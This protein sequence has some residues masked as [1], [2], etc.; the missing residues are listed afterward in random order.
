MS[1]DQVGKAIKEAFLFFKQIFSDTARLLSIVEESMNRHKLT[2]LWGSAAMWD[3]SYAFYGDHGW[4]VHYL[5]RLFVKLPQ[6]DKKTSF[7]EEKKGAFVNVYFEPEK[8]SEPIIVYGIITSI[9]D[10]IWPAWRSLLAVN[11]GPEFVTS[12]R[13]SDWTKYEVIGRHTLLYKVLPLTD[14]KNKEIV[15]SICDETVVM[16][17][18]EKPM[19]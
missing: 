16:Y 17:N 8:L 10:D 5:S 19:S 6:K 18:L 15:E 11:E 1:E 9:D 13:V 14:V 7:A 3:R 2:A 12:E 4:I